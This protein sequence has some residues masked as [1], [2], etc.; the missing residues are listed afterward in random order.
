MRLVALRDAVALGISNGKGRNTNF[1]LAKFNSFVL[2]RQRS[3]GA[4][5]VNA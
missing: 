2:K 1:Y 5:F 4:L 3:L